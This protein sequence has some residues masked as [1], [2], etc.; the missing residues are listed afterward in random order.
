[1][2]IHLEKFSAKF[3]EFEGR[4][5]EAAVASCDVNIHAKAAFYILMKAFSVFRLRSLLLSQRVN[6]IFC[7][8]QTRSNYKCRREIKRH[9][10]VDVESVSGCTSKISSEIVRLKVSRFFLGELKVLVQIQ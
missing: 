2:K 8:A 4:E 10:N 7:V 5:K 9:E 1:M 3:S 6:E